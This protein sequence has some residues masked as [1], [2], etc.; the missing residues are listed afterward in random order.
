MASNTIMPN[1]TICTLRTKQGDI[2]VLINAAKES[3]TI[4]DM[5]DYYGDDDV[6]IIPINN[7]KLETLI[8]I[9]EYCNYV[10]E[11]KLSKEYARE[12]VEG[13]QGI[14][15]IDPWFIEYLNISRNA[16][17]ELLNVANFLDI[18]IL[19]RMI[20]KYC[21]SMMENPLEELD[22]FFGPGNYISQELHQFFI[23]DDVVPEEEIA[24]AIQEAMPENVMLEYTL[25]EAQMLE[26][27]MIAFGILQREMNELAIQQEEIIEDNFQENE[28]LE[29]VL[30]ENVI[31]EVTQTAETAEAA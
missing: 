31:Q 17:F 28:I 18:D 7:I 21:S 11:N 5:L 8:K 9:M 2:I 27:E 16:L 30:L 10:V 6:N 3:N 25:Q 4:K 1:N 13:N 23:V 20:C 14:D 22:G 15:I 12:Y 29:Y 19:L 26:A 24:E